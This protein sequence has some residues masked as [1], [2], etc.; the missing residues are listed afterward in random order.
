VNW[1]VDKVLLVGWPAQRAKRP[2][3]SAERE[4]ATILLA[5]S[6]AGMLCKVKAEEI[7]EKIRGGT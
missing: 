4:R 3:D 7:L 5:I 1:V 6:A 2:R